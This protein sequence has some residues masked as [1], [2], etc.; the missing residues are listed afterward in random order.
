MRAVVNAIIRTVI[1]ILIGVFM[2]SVNI[3]IDIIIVKRY[4]VVIIL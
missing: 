2:I 3:L 1:P 4:M